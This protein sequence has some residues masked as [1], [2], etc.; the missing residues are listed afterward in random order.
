MAER[1]A[2]SGS[3]G[4]SRH[5]RAASRVDWQASKSTLGRIIDRILG[6]EVTAPDLGALPDP[7]ATFGQLTF[8]LESIVVV[9]DRSTLWSKA[10]FLPADGTIVGSQHVAWELGA[11]DFLHDLRVIAQDRDFIPMAIFAA[12][13]WLLIGKTMLSIGGAIMKIYRDLGAE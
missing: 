10:F 8:N 3:R 11:D 9:P 4:V 6:V 5:A 2:Q 7:T 1:P 12:L 13:W